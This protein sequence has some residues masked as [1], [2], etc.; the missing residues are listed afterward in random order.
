MMN[1]LNI[2]QFPVWVVNSRGQMLCFSYIAYPL[3]VILRRICLFY[4]FGF[5]RYFGWVGKALL[6][7]RTSSMQVVS[8]ENYQLLKCHQMYPLMLEYLR[9]L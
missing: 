3:P 9:Y 4:N 5:L 1:S 6:H 7:A 8:H 2:K